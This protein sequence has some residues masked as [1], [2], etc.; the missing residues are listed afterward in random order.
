MIDQG[1][2]DAMGAMIDNIAHQWRQPLNALGITVQ[3]LLFYYDRGDFDRRQLR[4]G[5]EDS[6]GLIRHM[7]QTIDDFRDFFRPNREKVEFDVRESVT[8]TLSL[9]AGTFEALH[10][11]VAIEVREGVALDGH[12][13]NLRRSHQY[14][15]QRQGR[16]GRSRDLRAAD[17]DL[18]PKG[19]IEG[20]HR[21]RRQRGR[22]PGGDPG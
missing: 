22:N 8:K 16:A 1:R 13:K 14:H 18:A 4:Q 20:R 3:K 12:P 19:G 9:L 15:H 7:S 17:R 2:Q 5:V 11:E 21:C 10:I 6:M